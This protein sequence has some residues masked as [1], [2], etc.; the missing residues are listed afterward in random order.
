MFD[1]IKLMNLDK[2]F[3]SIAAGALAMG[4][5]TLI[6]PSEAPAGFVPVWSEVVCLDPDQTELEI[7]ADGTLYNIPIPK[8]GTESR[9]ILENGANWRFYYENGDPTLQID[10]GG[11]SKEYVVNK[12]PLC[13]KVS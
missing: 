8:P 5:V 7:F 9:G 13:G 3:G 4:A 2:K 12:D 10:E 11:G 1:T 6:E